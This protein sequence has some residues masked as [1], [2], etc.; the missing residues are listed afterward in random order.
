MNFLK[1]IFNKVRQKIELKSMILLFTNKSWI[2]ICQYPK[3]KHVYIFLQ[4][5]NKLIFSKDGSI[6]NLEWSFYSELRSITLAFSEKTILYNILALND[7][8]SFLKWTEGLI[9]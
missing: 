6:Q 1:E 3:E 2:D 9:G 8:F 4:D 5:Q 7:F